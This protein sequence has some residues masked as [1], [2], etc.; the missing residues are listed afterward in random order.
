MRKQNEFECSQD[1]LTRDAADCASHIHSV[2]D[3]MLAIQ[4]EAQR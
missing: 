1:E 4:V 3:A 2:C